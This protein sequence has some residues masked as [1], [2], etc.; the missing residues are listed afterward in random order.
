MHR[1]LAQA[2]SHV[3]QLINFITKA[4]CG[5]IVA[6]LMWPLLGTV[7]AFTCNESTNVAL[8]ANG[9]TATASSAYSGFAAS[10]AI[11][12]DRKGLFVWQ[13][14]YWSTA[15]T[16]SHWLEVQFNGSRVSAR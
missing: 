14:G 16:G 15:S 7:S 9:A 5:A 2:S 4:A 1:L 11:N 6:A 13:D 3:V 10:G 8:A 12:G